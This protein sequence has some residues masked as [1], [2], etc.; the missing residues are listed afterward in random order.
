MLDLTSLC[1]SFYV[2]FSKFSAHV[3]SL[4]LCSYCYALTDASFLFVHVAS[5]YE[6]LCVF[7]F[8]CYSW[9][10]VFSVLWPKNL[11]QWNA[12]VYYS[13]LNHSLLF[14]KLSY[15]E[16]PTKIHLIVSLY[17]TNQ[18]VFVLCLTLT[19][20]WGQRSKSLIKLMYKMCHK[21]WM[22]EFKYPRS[23]RL[24][25][26]HLQLRV[27]F[28]SHGELSSDMKCG[29]ECPESD[30]SVAPQNAICWKLV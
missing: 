20:E 19:H 7:L 29:M 18:F 6:Y 4:N 12:D 10:I 26:V 16:N 11:L 9:A 17:Y 5:I 24:F 30:G 13:Q 21:G 1:L 28:W 23:G 25:F 27:P 14:A 2:V 8:T 15:T 3:W 22:G